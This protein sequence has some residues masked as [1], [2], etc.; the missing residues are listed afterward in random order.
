[1]KANI[2]D[3]ISFWRF[4][5]R[6]DRVNCYVLTYPQTGSVT[7]SGDYGVYI[8]SG[9][10]FVLEEDYTVLS[11]REF[12]VESGDIIIFPSGERVRI[13]RFAGKYGFVPEEESK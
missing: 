10:D 13:I 9:A 7:G 11:R 2:G 8:D 6:S 1:M 3:R 4:F 12:T 5:N